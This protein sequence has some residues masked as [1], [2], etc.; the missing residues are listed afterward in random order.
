[1]TLFSALGLLVSTFSTTVS[2]GTSVTRE[3]V[4]DFVRRG[5]IHGVPYDGARSLGVDALPELA[6]V[7][8][9]PAMKRYWANAVA[10][11]AY[12]DA[13]KSFEIL[14]S[15]LWESFTGEVDDTTFIALVALPCVLGVI[16]NRREADVVKYLEFGSNPS[17]WESLPWRGRGRSRE[18]LGLLFSQLSINGLAGSASP[19]AAQVLDRLKKKPYSSEQVPTIIGAIRANEIVRTKGIRHYVT[20]TQRQLGGN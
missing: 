16:S 12:I 18:S 7:L 13:P 15:F 1:M 3:Q 9:D 10:T 2:A 4:R 5:Y 19:R 11:I 6:I 8:R 17:T 14:H 20:T